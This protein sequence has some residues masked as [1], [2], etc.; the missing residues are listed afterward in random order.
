MRD[1]QLF[2]KPLCIILCLGLF[3]SCTNNNRNGDKGYIQFPEELIQ[4]NS[5]DSLIKFDHKD[6][7][8]VVLVNGECQACYSE[9]YRWEK[10]ITD[11]PNIFTGIPIHFILHG[12]NFKIPKRMLN[13]PGLQNFTFW[14]DN[15][16]H[17]ITKNK[18]KPDPFF[19]TFLIDQNNRIEIRGN[20]VYSSEILSHYEAILY[21]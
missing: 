17:F 16:N 6:K 3:L 13:K 19:N 8:I 20:P 15:M 14:L 10:L 5:K 12:Q 4:I 18:I 9:I 1:I 7:L 21:N 2:I 11:N